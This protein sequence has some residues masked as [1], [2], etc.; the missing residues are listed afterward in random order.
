MLAVINLW[1]NK[2]MPYAFLWSAFVLRGTHMTRITQGVLESYNGFRK[3]KRVKNRLPHRY[4]NET[5]ELVDGQAIEYLETIPEG[6]FAKIK[7]QKRSHADCEGDNKFMCA[8]GYDKRRK[9][10]FEPPSQQ[11]NSMG[12]QKA[13]NLQ[14]VLQ[15]AKAKSILKISKKSSPLQANYIDILLDDKKRLNNFV[16]DAYLSVYANEK[17]GFVI[18]SIPAHGILIRNEFEPNLYSDVCIF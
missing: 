15:Q 4:I 14:L 7:Q 17:M 9:D 10:S 16:I 1:L 2:Y 8:E 3:N 18:N 12:Y 11:Q 5:F 6:P 13:A